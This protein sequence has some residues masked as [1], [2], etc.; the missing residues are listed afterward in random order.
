MYDPAGRQLDRAAL[1]LAPRACLLCPAPAVEC[2][3]LGRHPLPEVLD[4]VRGL[5]GEA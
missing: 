2:I 4:R 1:G 3:R 5:L